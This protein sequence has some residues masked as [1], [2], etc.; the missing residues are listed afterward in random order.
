MGSTGRVSLQEYA[1]K[2]GVYLQ[3]GGT[4]ANPSGNP[5]LID[6]GFT[7]KEVR[8][9]LDMIGEVQRE[10]GMTELVTTLTSNT[11]L[12]DFMGKGEYDG[13]VV[14][15]NPNSTAL[16]EEGF[17]TIYHEAGHGIVNTLSNRFFAGKSLNSG[18]MANRIVHEAQS[19]LRN[20][21]GES[22]SD[23]ISNYGLTNNNELVA[24]AVRDYM[25]H[26]SNSAPMSQAI[27]HRLHNWVGKYNN[28]D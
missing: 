5:K 7:D 12:D 18:V 15:V 10:F 4:I 14:R 22:A 16:R 21:F 13:G 11:G 28:G 20:R 27:V 25:L 23:Y 2:Y 8:K 3:G 24:E 26:G 17:A 6:D 1:D 9:M 19:T